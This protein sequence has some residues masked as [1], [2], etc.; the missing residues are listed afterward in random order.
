MKLILVI[1][2]LVLLFGA[3]GNEAP[4]GALVG[5]D[6]ANQGPAVTLSTAFYTFAAKK[7]PAKAGRFY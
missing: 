5:F 1:V 6:I 3:A 7:R 2:V 4:Q